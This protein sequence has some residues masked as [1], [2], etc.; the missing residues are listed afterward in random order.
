MPVDLSA[1][2]RTKC[3][4]VALQ[5]IEIAQ[6]FGWRGVELEIIRREAGNRVQSLEVEEREPSA[7]ECDQLVPPESLE[8][9]VG[10]HRGQAQQVRQIRLCKRHADSMVLGDADRPLPPHELA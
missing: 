9:A 2:K 4:T 7:I 6:H 10:V 1:F 5:A 3:G 8:D